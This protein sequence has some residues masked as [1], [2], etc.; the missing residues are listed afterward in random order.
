MNWRERKG[1]QISRRRFLSLSAAAALSFLGTGCNAPRTSRDFGT[2]VS[3]DPHHQT[4]GS[5]GKPLEGYLLVVDFQQQGRKTL[6]GFNNPN[7]YDEKYN[8]GDCVQLRLDTKVPFLPWE[9]S[10]PAY[11]A[12]EAKLR[13]LRQK[14]VYSLDFQGTGDVSITVDKVSQSRC[15]RKS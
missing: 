9:R 5:N 4:T 1:P 14:G 13:R 7:S 6:I 2:V 10:G 3:E 11:E 8:R 15:N 12:A